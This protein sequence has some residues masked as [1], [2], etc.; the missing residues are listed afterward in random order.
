MEE[1]RDKYQKAQDAFDRIVDWKSVYQN[2]PST[3]P[4][5]TAR[6]KIKDQ[7][8]FDT[9]KPLLEDIKSIQKIVKN[10]YKRLWNASDE[11]LEEFEM[12]IMPN[13]DDASPGEVRIVD[14]LKKKGMPTKKLL[15]IL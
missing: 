5:Y 1:M 15:S 6:Q 10:S 3:L 4:L 12:D 14:K 9:W 11:L 2:P 13:I 7:V 8:L